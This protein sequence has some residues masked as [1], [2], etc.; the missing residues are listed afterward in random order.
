MHLTEQVQFFIQS[1]V[2][3]YVF[4]YFS[5]SILSVS[6]MPLVYKLEPTTLK[7]FTEKLKWFLFNKKQEAQLPQRDSARQLRTRLS[8]LA[9]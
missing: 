7:I 6:G 1:A 8:R 9:H 4:Y 2:Y 5:G 3:Y